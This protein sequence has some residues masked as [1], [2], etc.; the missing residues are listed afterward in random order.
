MNTSN[1]R[2]LL[3]CLLLTGFMGC[4]GAEKAISPELKNKIVYVSEQGI[5]TINPDGTDLKVIVALEKGGRFSNPKW[6]PDKRRIAFNGK[7]KGSNRIMIV[8]SDGSDLKI[9]GLPEPKPKKLKPG[10]VRIALGKYKFIFS[11]LVPFGQAIFIFS[12]GHGCELH[13]RYEQE[14]RDKN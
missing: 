11:R 8:N 10:E 2:I 5:C 1:L 4:E 7:V 9:F 6:S 12:S 13:R 14:R 3:L